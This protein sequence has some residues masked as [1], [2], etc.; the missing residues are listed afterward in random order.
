[1]ERARTNWSLSRD[2]CLAGH[3]QWADCAHCAERTDVEDWCRFCDGWI[4]T[5][6]GQSGGITHWRRFAHKSLATLDWDWLGPEVSEQIRHYA[7]GVPAYV[8]NGQGLF[9]GGGPGCGKTHIALGMGLVALAYGFSAYAATL[10]DL[11]LN[12]RHSFD[13]PTGLSEAEQME[14]LCDVDLLI[15]DDLGMEQ[16]TAWAVDRLAHVVNG[17][18]AR[19]KALLVTSNFHPA[20]LDQVWGAPMMSRLY[21]SCEMISLYGIDDF[22]PI[23]RAQSLERPA[24]FRPLWPGTEAEVVVG[25][26]EG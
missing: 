5:Q 8:P 7:Q 15:L 6:Y 23:E 16:P 18:Y 9:V 25:E 24:P 22:R 13:S 20:R 2:E 4:A 11:L 10:G 3:P 19:R 1:M 14:M 26:E 17:R 12:F 21:A